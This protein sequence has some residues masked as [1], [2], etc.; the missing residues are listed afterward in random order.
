M[1]VL[2]MHDLGV[3]VESPVHVDGQTVESGRSKAH[4]GVVGVV[5]SMVV[6]VSLCIVG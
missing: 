3:G 5:Q 2:V 6:K 4:G 1:R